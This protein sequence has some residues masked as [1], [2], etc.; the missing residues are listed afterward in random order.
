MKITSLPVEEVPVK[1]TT[2]YAALT[3]EKYRVMDK[4]G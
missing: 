3:I 4:R 2:G 1:D